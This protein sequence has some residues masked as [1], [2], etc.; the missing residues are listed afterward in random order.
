MSKLRK[1]LLGIIVVGII[2]TGYQIT[3]RIASEQR[4]TVVEIVADLDSFVSMSKKMRKTESDVLKELR[5]AGVNSIAVSEVTINELV[6]EGKI[7]IFENSEIKNNFSDSESFF[8][9]INSYIRDNGIE[10]KNL[11]LFT[12]EDINLYNFLKKSLGN[13]YSGRTVN[14]ESDNLNGVLV[15][16][17]I[18]SIGS[19][20]LGIMEEDLARA[21][22]MNFA[23]V[24]PRIQNYR[25]LTIEQIDELYD[26]LKKYK[27]RT[28]IFAG[29]EVLGFDSEDNEYEKLQ[30]IGEKFS[31][32]GQ[33][34]ITAILEKPSDTSLENVQRGI[35]KLA[36]YSKYV[37]TKVF[38][39][40]EAQLA[41]LSAS[42]VADQWGRAI[43]Q[44]NVRIIYLRPLNIS[45]K[46]A[47]QNFENTLDAVREITNRIE[48]MGMQRGIAKGFG[49]IN[50]NVIVKII[51]AIAT[52]AAGILILTYFFNK[53]WWMYIGLLLGSILIAF[54]YFVP[55]VYNQFGTLIDKF[56]AFAA[57]NIFPSLS[58]LYLIYEYKKNEGKKLT[59]SQLIRQSVLVLIVS[60]LIAAVGGIF[61]GAILSGSKYILKLDTFSGV[62][63]SFL[64]PLV[65]FAVAFVL[66]LGIYTDKDGRPLNLWLQVNK[67]I[68]TTVTVK[69]VVVAGVILLG[70]LIV[71]LRSGN[72][73]AAS[74]IEL[75]FRSFLEKYLVARPRTKEL[76]AFPILMLAVLFATGKNK[77]FFFI[78]VAMGMIGI[79]DIVN[80]FCHLRM[81]ILVT[82][83]SSTYSLIFGVIIGSILVIVIKKILTINWKELLQK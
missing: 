79:E 65:F 38:S 8:N 14:F 29:S 2:I 13:R 42:D 12:T 61:V 78:T 37:N 83:L 27:V 9:N 31:S 82:T 43:S 40:D 23:N 51:I 62:K 35:T 46:T 81:P 15:D 5:S 52:F 34:I 28:I 68:N 3:L 19:V 41:K 6:E 30:Y 1:I 26:L 10:Y 80:S 70:L 55:S 72:T 44:R 60:I 7:Q 63:L 20:S 24:V 59:S 47:N 25:D 33:E 67:L 71:V 53:N 73:T 74:S 56:F 4:N 57:A 48:H 69:Y 32:E 54:I 75:A 50:Q 11:N 17:A 64:L 76:I 45:Y 39:V 22:Q 66:K 77:A 21:S 36:Q 58:V 16:Y 18:P 49:Q